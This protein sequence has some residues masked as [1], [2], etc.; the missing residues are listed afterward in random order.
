[1]TEVKRQSATVMCAVLTYK[2]SL[3]TIIAE[4]NIYLGRTN[5][6]RSRCST[7]ILSGGVRHGGA[8]KSPSPT[9]GSYRY[10]R[11]RP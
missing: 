11:N 3:M 10:G 1:M 2:V 4:W 5:T 7:E 6:L 9:I 8:A